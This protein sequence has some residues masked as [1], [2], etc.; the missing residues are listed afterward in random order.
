M[1]VYIHYKEKYRSLLVVSE[2]FV[3]GVIVEKTVCVHLL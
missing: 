1:K 3:L 2:E